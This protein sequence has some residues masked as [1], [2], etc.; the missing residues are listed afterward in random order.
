M[1]RS[2]QLSYFTPNKCNPKLSRFDT[3]RV[4]VQLRPFHGGDPAAA[5]PS[6][7]QVGLAQVKLTQVNAPEFEPTFYDVAI[8]G[9]GLVG[10]AAAL[11]LGDSGLRVALI[12]PTGDTIVTV[13]DL[14]DQGCDRSCDQGWDARV[15]AIS[16]ASRA[17]LESLG[18]WAHLPAARIAR[19]TRMEVFAALPDAAHP[20][21]H[22]ATE[23]ASVQIDGR[24]EFS[25]YDIGADALA[26]LLESR[27]LAQALARRLAETPNIAILRGACCAAFDRRPDRIELALADGRFLT[28]KLAVGA[29]G[30]NS[31]LREA[32]GIRCDQFD[33]QATAVVANFTVARDHHGT[34]FQWFATPGDGILAYLP[35]PGQRISIVWSC[36]SAHAAQLMALDP[37]D[38]VQQVAAAGGH[39]L[40][41]LELMTAPRSFPLERR[42]A[43][44]PTADRV[45]LVGDAAHVV[46]PLAG[47]GVNLGFGDIHELA[48]VLRARELFRDCGDERVLARYRRAR[49]EAILAM[50]SLTHGLERLFAVPGAAP[51]WL[52]RAGMTVT[53]RLPLVRGLLAQHAIG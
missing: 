18:V 15:Y 40:G 39:C 52:R 2:N 50:S 16:P 37:G 3:T 38:F 6:T 8:I 34:A 4:K 10:A 24:I 12:D 47:Q 14:I 51:A 33:Y 29:D 45:A 25:A 19:C 41:A 21:A 53:N 44:S 1:P 22:H 42:I 20:S 49:A 5:R 46:H 26:Y 30:A 23:R 48:K 28:A 17:L 13:P 11:A 7:P 36:A 32:A 35:L 43:R 27:S 9:A 31:W